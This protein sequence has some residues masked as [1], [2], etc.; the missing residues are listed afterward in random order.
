MRD[1]GYDQS[2]LRQME[3]PVN[4]HSVS[5]THRQGARK[6]PDSSHLP[7]SH[8]FTGAQVEWQEKRTEGD[9]VWETGPGCEVQS[10]P[11]WQCECRQD[12]LGPASLV[13]MVKTSQMLK[14]SFVLL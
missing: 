1:F 12:P 5:C 10:V 14:G 4:V 7:N 9:Q 13:R 6:T 2:C 11:S 3:G 8:S